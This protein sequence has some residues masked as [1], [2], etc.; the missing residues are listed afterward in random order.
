MTRVKH[1]C[2]HHFDHTLYRN[3]N[4]KKKGEKKEE[5]NVNSGN[6]EENLTKSAQYD[7]GISQNC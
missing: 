3:D 5:N 6:R 2:F 1:L 4:N 7:L